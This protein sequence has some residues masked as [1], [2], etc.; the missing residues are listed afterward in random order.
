MSHFHAHF[1]FAFTVFVLRT[2]LIKVFEMGTLQLVIMTVMFQFATGMTCFSSHNSI[3]REWLLH[4]H[5]NK[6]VPVRMQCKQCQC[7]ESK[8]LSHSVLWEMHWMHLV[9]AHSWG[10]TE[11]SYCQDAIM[12][13]CQTHP[14]WASAVCMSLYSCVCSYGAL[15]FSNSTCEV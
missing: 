8:A 3:K 12:E 9:T 15:C 11:D 14:L 1:C 5:G 13:D 10:F 7:T 6:R 2:P 4:Y